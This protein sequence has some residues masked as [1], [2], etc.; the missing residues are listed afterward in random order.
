MSLHIYNA[1]VDSR[2]VLEITCIKHPRYEGTRQTQAYLDGCL[3]CR[4]VYAVH[5]TRAKDLPGQTV[6]VLRIE[7]SR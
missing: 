7:A 5:K 4:A 3:G 2:D 6:P 1:T